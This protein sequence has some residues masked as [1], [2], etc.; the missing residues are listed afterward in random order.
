MDKYYAI[1]I[2]GCGKNRKYT[3]R[4]VISANATNPVTGKAW[5][6]EERARAEAED[7]GINVAVCGDL[8]DIIGAY[9]NHVG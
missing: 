9:R 5:R 4:D 7:L 8:W 6:T 3:L 1:E 2:I